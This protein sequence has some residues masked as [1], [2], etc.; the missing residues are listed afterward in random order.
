M[1]CCHRLHPEVLSHYCSVQRGD[2]E[3]HVAAGASGCFRT[4]IVKCLRNQERRHEQRKEYEMV[5]VL[6]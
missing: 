6:G 5:R 1:F 2:L 3:A 4:W